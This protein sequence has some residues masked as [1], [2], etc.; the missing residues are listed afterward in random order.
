MVNF[1]TIV[2]Y[3]KGTFDFVHIDIWRPTKIA[4]LRGKHWFVTFVDDY[5]MKFVS[6]SNET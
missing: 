6:L 3:T 4:S 2:Y 5:L 1:G